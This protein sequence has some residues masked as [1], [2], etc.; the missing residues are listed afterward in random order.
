MI[1]SQF[2]S[3]FW[4]AMT[5]VPESFRVHMFEIATKLKFPE[6]VCEDLIHVSRVANQITHFILRCSH[7]AAECLM[8]LADEMLHETVCTWI[9][10]LIP[11]MLKGFEV[12]VAFKQ[13]VFQS[14]CWRLRRHGQVKKLAYITCLKREKNWPTGS[15]DILL[16]GLSSFM[17]ISRASAADSASRVTSPHLR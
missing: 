13:K 5:C 1:V 12:A 10:Q 15:V 9:L 3:I 4:Q 11:L 7:V 17:D 14:L 8:E 16:D 2:S 6:A